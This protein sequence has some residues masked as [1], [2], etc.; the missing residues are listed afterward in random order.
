MLEDRPRPNAREAPGPDGATEGS[1]GGLET[2]DRGLSECTQAVLMVVQ[3]AERALPKPGIK[4]AY[5]LFQSCAGGRPHKGA[6]GVRG[7]SP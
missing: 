7:F 3:T 6:G 2:R 4:P 5:I 1:G